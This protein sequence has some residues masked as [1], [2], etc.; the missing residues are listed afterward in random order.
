M[1]DFAAPPALLLFR[2]HLLG[3]TVLALGAL[4]AVSGLIGFGGRLAGHTIA[5]AGYTD[6]TTRY[7]IV[8]GNNVIAAPANVIRQARARRDGVAARLDL[9]LRWPEM[10]GYSEAARDDFNNK[11]GA[12][13]LVFLSFEP[14]TMS[15]DMSGR[16]EPIYRML[17]TAQGKAGPAGI[18]FHD[19][20]PRSG[21]ADETLAVAQRPGA[22]PFVARCLTGAGAAAS[23]APCERDITVGDEMSLTYRFPESGLKDWPQL[24]A[25]VRRAAA[26]L[27]RSAR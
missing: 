24:E 6:A 15:R 25:A 8:I 3:R 14:K 11:D 9:Y 7:E 5:L 27:I 10:D 23:L 22:E 19:F 2:P 21:Y 17:V 1:T 4:I 16:W 18:A 13:R 12:R 26:G 20:T